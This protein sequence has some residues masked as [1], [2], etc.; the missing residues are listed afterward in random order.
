MTGSDTNGTDD[1]TCS[2]LGC[3]TVSPGDHVVG[4]S[5][6]SD[7]TNN[8]EAGCACELQTSCDNVGTDL[9]APC[10]IVTSAGISQTIGKKEDRVV[11][12]GRDASAT[13]NSTDLCH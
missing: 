9:C 2:V 11:H 10:E 12:V 8:C 6:V 4:H 1:L 7:L 3:A 5:C 13:S